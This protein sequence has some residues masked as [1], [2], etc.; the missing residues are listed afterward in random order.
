M[1]SAAAY[2][3]LAALALVRAA[4]VGCGD[5]S[6]HDDATATPTRAVVTVVF[7]TAVRPCINDQGTTIPCPTATPTPQPTCVPTLGVPSCCAAHCEP[8]P[9]IRAG[10]YA[11]GCQDCIERAEC[12]LILIPTCGPGEPIHIPPYGN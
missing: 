9:T 8:C 10:C 11:Q 3:P 5:G 12:D 6:D 2:L 4:V 7:P 1:R